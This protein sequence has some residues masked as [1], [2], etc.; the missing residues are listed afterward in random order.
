MS[1][2]SNGTEAGNDQ[3]ARTIHVGNLSNQVTEALFYEL[4]L[5]VGAFTT[6]K[7]CVANRKCA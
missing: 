4:F 6:L 5:Q 7:I 3:D 2:P 1:A